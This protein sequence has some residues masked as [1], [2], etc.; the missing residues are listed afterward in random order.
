[1]SDK[2]DFNYQFMENIDFKACL[3]SDKPLHAAI[4]QMKGQKN[5]AGLMFEYASHLSGSEKQVI[6][7]SVHHFEDILMTILEGVQKAF[8]D[9]DVVTEVQRRIKTGDLKPTKKEE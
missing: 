3:K 2:K 4:D 1:M 6:D 8:S 9:P 7:D 5:A